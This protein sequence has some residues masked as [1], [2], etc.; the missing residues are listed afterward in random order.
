MKKICAL[1]IARGGSKRIKNKNIIKI[2][3]NLLIWYTLNELM[4]SEI[5]NKI[6]IM[7]DSD[8]IKRE[9]EKF[10]FDKVH[11]IGRSK[12]SSTN[13]AQSELAISEFVK[14]FDYDHIYFVQI[15]NIFLKKK[16]IDKSIGIY[17]KKKYDSMLSV[18]KSDKFI[19]RNKNNNFVPI[20]YDLKNRP[21]K[22]KL[23]DI[24]FLENGSFYIFN[25]LGFKKNN[26]RLFGKI[27]YYP[28][29]KETYFD[30]DELDDLKI[31][32]KLILD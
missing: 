32:A 9:T 3:K 26:V 18:I 27:G 10:N 31:A 24:Y 2:N 16:D 1:I 13:N 19:W 21:L 15:T 7:T 12:K 29:G 20:N 5:I 11:V 30:I 14:S 17:F 8:L 28:M 6:F 25:T 23:K 4:K 22:K